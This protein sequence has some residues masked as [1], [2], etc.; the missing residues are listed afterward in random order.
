MALKHNFTPLNRQ[1]ILMTSKGLY[2]YAR[3]LLQSL[4]L[5][6]SDGASPS[7]CSTDSPKRR[8]FDVKYSWHFLYTH[9]ILENEVSD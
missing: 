1:N 9:Y 8:M 3:V 7:V 2:K 5:T 6:I 4:Q